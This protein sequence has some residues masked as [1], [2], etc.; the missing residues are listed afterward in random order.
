MIPPLTLPTVSIA[1]SAKTDPQHWVRLSWTLRRIDDAAEF[2]PET[3]GWGFLS[4]KTG[5][6]GVRR[7]SGSEDASN[8]SASVCERVSGQRCAGRH[9][10]EKHARAG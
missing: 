1:L 6:T 7:L 10:V 4:A 8:P 9:R 3:L 5:H 2:R